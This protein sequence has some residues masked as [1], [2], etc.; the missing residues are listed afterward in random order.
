MDVLTE[1]IPQGQ[2]RRMAL[3]VAEAAAE[4][5][6]GRDHIYGAIRDGR[7]EARKFGRRTLI[8]YDALHRFLHQLPP[9]KPMRAATRR[10]NS[11]RPRPS[12][13]GSTFAVSDQHSR[14]PRPPTRCGAFLVWRGVSFRRGPYRPG[15]SAVSHAPLATRPLSAE[16]RSFALSSSGSL[17]SVS[18]LR[19]RTRGWRRQGRWKRQ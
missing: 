18:L 3:S 10:R 9:L 14:S 1:A 17:L 7:L 12:E 6:V 11:P 2:R 4:A 13:S 16:P 19:P 15:G 5:S 8:T